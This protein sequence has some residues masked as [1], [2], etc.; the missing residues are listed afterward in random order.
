MTFNLRSYPRPN[1]DNGIAITFR[2]DVANTPN[3]PYIAQGVQWLQ[4]I[5][6]TWTLVMGQDELQLL[7]AAEAV[8]AAG[9][10]PAARLITY[11]DKPY[12]A[13]EN[14]VK[15]FT[16][17]GIPAYLQAFNEP[18]DGREWLKDKNRSLGRVGAAMANAMIRIYDA[19]GYPGVGAVLAEQEWLS[20]F[21]A[22]KAAGRMDIWDRAW[23]CLHN[24]G[25]NHPPEYPDDGVNQNG[26][27]V[28]LGE[29]NSLQFSLPINEVNALRHDTAM[30]GFPNQKGTNALPHHGQ[31]VLVDDTDR[32]SVV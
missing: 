16:Q 6:A 29:Y 27:P 9:I 1:K 14:I 4:Q 20:V 21:S 12:I 10:M 32:K 22:V 23:W 28:T 2:Q 19:G 11:L 8:Y 15:L 3:K 5:N 26:D 25:S 7:A 30:V 18:M 13:W 17:A 31:T 24:Y